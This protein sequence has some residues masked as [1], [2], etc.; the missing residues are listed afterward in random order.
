VGW[1]HHSWR[2]GHVEA[3]REVGP[4]IPECR[5]E[6][7]TLPVVLATF[8]IFS[9]SAIQMVSCHNWW[10]WIKSGSITMTRRQNNSQ[11]GGSI[12][13]PPSP[14]PKIPSVKS[15]GKVLDSTFWDQS[16]PPNWLT[17]KGPNYQCRELLMSAGAIEGHFK[18]KTPCVG[19]SPRGYCSCTT[20]P[21]LTRHLQPR[22]NWPTWASNVFITHPIL[23]IL[24]LQTTTSF[25][26]LRKQFKVRHLSK[27]KVIA[28]AET[29]L[30]G[31]YSEFFFEWCKS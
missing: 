30:D 16:H 12:A 3:L 14:P 8:W 11:W 5:S 22:W 27:T 23:Q 6:T 2:F 9:F 18:G 15:A 10:P 21:R 7:S 17:S 4:E 31:Q 24:P 28:A 1:V 26:G 13:A 20:M 25:P 29:W 19:R